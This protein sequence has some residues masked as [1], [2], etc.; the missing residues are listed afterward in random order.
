MRHH[1]VG[2]DQVGALALGDQAMRRARAPK[3]ATSVW[4]PRSRASRG[5]VGGGLDAERRDAA[6]D[7][8][9]QQVAVVAGD[10]HDQAVPPQPEALDRHLDVAAGVRD[11]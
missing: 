8:V 10:L 1:V 3:N 4:I 9:P 5:H 11:P 2:G 6:L 7:D